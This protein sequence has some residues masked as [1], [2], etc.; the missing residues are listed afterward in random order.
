MEI[1][2]RYSPEELN[3]FPKMLGELVMALEEGPRDV[4]GQLFHDLALHNK[5]ARQF[6]TPYDVCRMMAS[7]TVGDAGELQREIAERGFVKTQ[8]PAC[9]SGAMVIALAEEM[10]TAGV[11]YQKH[12]HVTAVDLDPKC[13]HMAYLQFSLLHI[14]ASPSP[15]ASFRCSPSSSQPSL[16][17]AQLLQ[18][19]CPLCL[20]RSVKLARCREPDSSTRCCC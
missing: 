6:F 8:E 4:L 2:K 14:P 11:N 10:K 5:H 16:P 19:Q 13:V 15:R 18:P 9:G 20:R 17:W 7:M 1:I 12:L 3:E